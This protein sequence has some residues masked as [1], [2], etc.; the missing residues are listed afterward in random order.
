MIILVFFTSK[1]NFK[2][3]FYTDLEAF[4]L[5]IRSENRML[6]HQCFLW[7]H[8]ATL[9][10]AWSGGLVTNL[11]MI[12]ALFD[13]EHNFGENRD[14]RLNFVRNT[15]L[16]RVLCVP[17]GLLCCLVGSVFLPKPELEHQML[18]LPLRPPWKQVSHGTLNTV[19]SQI[20]VW[21]KSTVIG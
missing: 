8:P 11:E 14:L 3:F 4:S 5:Y 9:K 12:I 7:Q 19:G 20:S 18:V 6:L 21:L 17:T 1:F 13:F 2:F 10:L 15:L 16:L